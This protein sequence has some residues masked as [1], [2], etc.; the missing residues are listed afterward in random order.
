MP[1][2]KIF[3]LFLALALNACG[4][5]TPPPEPVFN[6]TV[7]TKTLFLNPTW[8][9][10]FPSE[11]LEADATL[12]GEDSAGKSAGSLGP[13][14]AQRENNNYKFVFSEVPTGLNAQIDA[15]I[16]I[17]KGGPLAGEENL[18][19]ECRRVAKLSRRI[20]FAGP[21]VHLE[22]SSADFNFSDDC[23]GDG[24]A[25]WIEF[26]RG[27][28]VSSKDSDGDG[29]ADLADL[30]PLDVSE[31]FD[32]DVDGLG[33]NSDNC[34]LLVN[35]EQ[36]DQDGDGFGDLC[37]SDID[38][39]GFLNDLELSLGLDPSNSDTDGDSLADQED[40]C[41]L[42]QNLLQENLDGDESGDI[43][44]E[45]RDGD[46]VANGTDNCPDVANSAQTNGDGDPLG[47]LCDCDPDR[48][49]RYQ[50]AADEPDF[51]SFDSN[52][53]GADGTLANA[54]FLSAN[55]GHDNNEGNLQAPVRTLLRA[56]ALALEAGKDV[57]IENGSYPLDAFSLNRG[58]RL[59]G[60]YDEEGQRCVYPR[61]PDETVLTAAQPIVIE[62]VNNSIVLDGLQI[63][64][65]M[66]VRNSSVRLKYDEIVGGTTALTV[67]GASSV[68]V[69]S[70]LID[71][72]V[73]IDTADD[74]LLE[75]NV[76]RVGAARI[77]VGLDI[78]GASPRVQNNTI[79]ATSRFSAGGVSA[80]ATSI[81]LSL[82]NALGLNLTN[83]ILITGNAENQYGLYCRGLEPN[84]S[85]ITNNLFASFP[86]SG[87]FSD[88]IPKSVSCLG[89]FDFLA[90]D[91]LDLGNGNALTNFDY[92]EGLTYG[93]LL[94]NGYLNLGAGR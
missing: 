68:T 67:S 66:V 49:D 45:D 64:D 58:V 92:P 57:Y 52:C 59:Y 12:K 83:N 69:D 10:G 26:Q 53:D 94:N 90:G 51:D 28:K 88:A 1:R 50:T 37:D 16:E 11:N 78:R 44:D 41:P 27:L 54:V 65:G 25:N 18:S 21:E 6:E 86:L 80:S 40:N 76:I 23:D 77:A 14:D 13:V 63:A 7:T 85:G 42:R 62:N 22:A 60:G 56:I 55:R 48:G 73:L 19:A 15:T 87:F 5:E 75:K 36:E 81:A 24:L 9:E 33:D 72:G 34:P 29:T 70:S 84:S 3:I 8:P 74:V 30:F 32:A 2:S 20:D 39:D 71:G 31:A 35:L 4:S 93:T 79:D 17:F 89:E 46:D 61:C 43:C 91:G 38:N 47:N 82:E